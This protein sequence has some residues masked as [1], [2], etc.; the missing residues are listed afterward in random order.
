MT[1]SITSEVWLPDELF[2][3]HEMP[4]AAGHEVWSRLGD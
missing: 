2:D 4:N 3:P 1:A